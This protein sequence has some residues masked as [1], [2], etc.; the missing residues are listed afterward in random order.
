MSLFE[1]NWSKASH[2][3][4]EWQLGSSFYA[5]EVQEGR[6]HEVGKPGGDSSRES[7]ITALLRGQLIAKLCD[8]GCPRTV[9]RAASG[10]DH[11]LL[12]KLEAWGVRPPVTPQ[13]GSYDQS[14][15]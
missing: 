1:P 14:T 4:R 2:A 15:L 13:L 9:H 7:W 11:P 6:Q 3:P 10:K 8:P 5:S 12:Q